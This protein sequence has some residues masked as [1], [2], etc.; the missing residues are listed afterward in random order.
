VW[1]I[2]SAHRHPAGGVAPVTRDV[3][4]KDRRDG[5][6]DPRRPRGPSPEK[7]FSLRLGP[8]REATEKR[9]EEVGVPVRRF[10]LDA[11]KEKLERS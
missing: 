3:T 5:R 1:P 6:E 7:P 9:A 8:L 2:V 11:I 4:V 10:I